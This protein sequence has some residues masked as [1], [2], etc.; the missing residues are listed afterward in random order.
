MI[1]EEFVEVETGRGYDALARRPE[2]KSALEAAKKIGTP[3][4]VATLEQFPFDMAHAAY[5]ACR[6]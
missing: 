2:L 4:I 5:P 1:E 3:L 6:K